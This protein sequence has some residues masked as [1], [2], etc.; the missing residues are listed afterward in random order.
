MVLVHKLR[1]SGALDPLIL[2]VFPL[3]H[4]LVAYNVDI[5]DCFA[6][7]SLEFRLHI[8]VLLVDWDLL[9]DELYSNKIRANFVEQFSAQKNQDT[10]G[11]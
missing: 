4:E 1:K 8:A 5:L 6:C 11:H 3:G 9:L 7:G 2:L 10:A